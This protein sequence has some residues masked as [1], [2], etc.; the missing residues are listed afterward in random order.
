MSRSPA[1]VSVAKW[2]ATTYGSARRVR[3]RQN[4]NQ[5]GVL[6][7]LVRS[8]GNRTILLLIA[9]AL[10]ASIVVLLPASRASAACSFYRPSEARS[11]DFLARCAGGTPTY[12]R[13]IGM[14]AQGGAGAPAKMG[15][16]YGNH[17]GLIGMG[18]AAITLA[19]TKAYVNYASN[20][21]GDNVPWPDLTLPKAKKTDKDNVRYRIYQVWFKG[22]SKFKKKPGPGKTDAWKYGLTEHSQQNRR[23]TEGVRRCNRHKSTVVGSCQSKWVRQNIRGYGRAR[24]Y[25]AA[26]AAKYKVRRG[27]CPIGMPRCL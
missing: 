20:L 17:A 14:P 2:E 1:R 21:P 8:A 4:P 18:T 27:R 9:V 25:E 16:K 6:M 26:Y 19:A 23:R 3:D 7:L 24:V 13:R 12:G 5:S 10:I 15:P 22:S 11:A